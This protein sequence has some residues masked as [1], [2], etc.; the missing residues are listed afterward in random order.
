MSTA[1]EEPDAQLDRGAPAW[2]TFDWDDLKGL[3]RYVSPRSLRGLRLTADIGALTQAPDRVAAETSIAEALYGVLR[4]RGISYARE[5]WTGLTRQQIRHPRWLIED[6]WGTC[7]DLAVTYAAMC[8]EAHLAPLLAIT[9]RHALVVLQPGR[10]HAP[11]AVP[12]FSAGWARRKP[13]E[14]VSGILE[15]S[16]GDWVRQSLAARELLAV[17]VVA[18]TSTYAGDFDD[19]LDRGGDYLSD[20]TVFLDVAYL[21]NAG[22]RPLPPPAERPSIRTYL[23]G[24]HQHFVRYADHA[25]ILEQ[26]EK[27]SG[28]VVLVATAGQGKSTLA[29]QVV[30]DAPFG[31]GWFLNASERRT[32]IGSLAAADLAERNELAP[33]RASADR[34]G[35]SDDALMRLAEAEGQWVVVYDNADG[36]PGNILP[37]MPRP[38]PGQLVLV[39]TT[40][41]EW[42]RVP[43]IR[44]LRLPA[45]SDETVAAELSGPELVELVAG[46]ALLLHAFRALL[47]WSGESPAAVAARAPTDIGAEDPTRAPATLWA[48]VRERLGGAIEPFCLQLAYLPPDQQPLELLEALNPDAPEFTAT[49]ADTGLVTRERGALRL[50]RLFGDAIRAD[51]RAREPDLDAQ[52]VLG[53]ANSREAFQMLDRYGDRDTLFRLDERVRELDDASSGPDERLGTAL[54][55]VAELLEP[56]GHT[57]LSGQT[58]A[59]ASRHLTHRIELLAGS[60]HGRARTVN[61]HHAGNEKMLREAL[62]WAARAEELL[63][64]LPGHEG[65]ADRCLAMQGLLK[66]KLAKFPGPGGTTLEL[67]RD[68]LGVIEEAHRK[69]VARLDPMDPE[70][71]RSEFNLA[72]IRIELAKLEHSAARAHLDTADRVYASVAERRER[73]YGRSV[74][75]H[76]AACVVGR[77]YVGYYRALLL[78]ATPQVRT[79]WLRDATAYADEAL[80][81]REALEGSLDGDETRKVL[82]FLAKVALARRVPPVGAAHEL[83]SVQAEMS[84]ELEFAAMRTLPSNTRSLEQSIAEWVFSPALAAVVAAFGVTAPEPGTELGDALEWLEEF[85]LRWD[86]RGGAERNLVGDQRLDAAT[87]D[88]VLRA[89]AALGLVGTSAPAAENYDHVLILGGLVRACIARPIYAAR[90]LDTDEI[91]AR[92]ITALGGFRELKGNELDLAASLGSGDLVDEFHAMDAGVRSAFKVDAPFDD[93]G[94][95]SDVVG[96]SWAVREYRLPTEGVVR[97]VGAPS[98]EPGVRRANTPDTYAWY[99]SEL[100]R[101]RPGERVLIVTSDIYVPYQH[102]DALRMLALPYSVEVDAVGVAP[103]DAHPSLVQTFEAHNYLQEFRS[104]IRAFRALHERL[105]AV[106]E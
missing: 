10:E 8:L 16:D 92:D 64:S 82:R 25:G 51:V 67:L 6:G 36:D 96:A 70:L 38:Q 24:G 34:V 77:G 29:R 40:N 48:A 63:L 104:T 17:D 13:D 80:G 26:L 61:Q 102:A 86:F 75:P 35:Y 7:L 46:R 5:S 98:S 78:P 30:L 31:A 84:R 105:A 62:S 22:A 87:R 15:V 32:L 27:Q 42:E 14:S 28:T 72:G 79:H 66:Q 59:R 9:E 68:A 76:I 41:P 55:M 74:H 81:Q 12:P 88:V 18:A 52:V 3:A 44:A 90:L 95:Q 73:I 1:R 103:G 58:Y 93:R 89:A 69:R 65:E 4:K 56:A 21:H 53:L 20:G 100:A 2:E 47:A 60:L 91:A 106:E 101:L 33:R 71:A 83:N 94:E 57:R 11:S 23:P 97:V 54:Y 43:G 19:A 45:L 49:L 39:T 50:H 85:S 99:A 37:L